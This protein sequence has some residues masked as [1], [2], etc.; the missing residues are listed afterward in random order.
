MYQAHK[1]HLNKL[2]AWSFHIQLFMKSF[3]SKFAYRDNEVEKDWKYLANFHELLEEWI[4]SSG[5]F[6][7]I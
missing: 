4:F 1:N 5:F 7:R 6:F 3:L 2:I